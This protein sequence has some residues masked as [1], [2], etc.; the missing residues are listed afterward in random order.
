VRV[1][2]R[3]V[4]SMRTTQVG[5]GLGVPFTAS[6][7][8]DSWATL[9]LR[10]DGSS[11]EYLLTFERVVAQDCLELVRNTRRYQEFP[12]GSRIEIPAVRVTGDGSEA[13]TAMV[14]LDALAFLTDAGV[15][16][17]RAN[18][19]D[20]LIPESPADADLLRAF[21]TTE[22]HVELTSNPSIRTFSA[23][24]DGDAITAL[25]P[26]AAG[27][28]LYA[29]ALRMGHPVGQFREFWRVLESA[30]ARQR[31]PLVRLLGAYDPALQIGF[32]ADE[33]NQLHVLR[34]RA[35]HAESRAGLVEILRIDREVQHALP[36]L[37]SLVERV[38]MTK[39]QWG[40]PTLDVHELLP[41]SSW[42]GPG[43]VIVL[44][45]TPNGQQTSP[46]R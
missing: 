4:V 1:R 18:I 30:F 14:F 5:A 25:I 31:R 43:G 46:E 44:I 24:I 36:R 33:I 11:D 37:K 12:N 17:S 16:V 45:Q 34:G 26:K 20:E 19:A 39:A 21:G 42:V 13:P 15:T 8:P 27:L 35:S 7:G 3:Y 41:P 22:T 2:S 29:D 9:D 32:S 40:V 6:L 28:R 23:R 38:V 10:E